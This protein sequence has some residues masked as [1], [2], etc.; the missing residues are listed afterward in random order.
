LVCSFGGPMEDTNLIRVLLVG[1]SRQSFFIHQKHLERNG[2]ECE[3]AECEETASEMIGRRQFDLV[4][5][6][7]PTRGTNSPS[8][9]VVLSGS[10][11]TLFYALRVE[12]G[13]WWVPIL[14][15]GEECFGAPVVRPGEFAKAIGEVLKEIRVEA[16][17]SANPVRTV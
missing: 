5:S 2:C 4:L 17:W 13:Y 15:L 12:V 11:T 7:H 8:L 14:R 3:F 10:P 1:D 9:G 6:L 16:T